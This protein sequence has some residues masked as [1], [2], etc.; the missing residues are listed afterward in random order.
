MAD[1]HLR[2][3]RPYLG[4]STPRPMWLLP[5]ASLIAEAA[6]RIYYRLTVAG[7]QVPGSGPVLLVANHPNSL[8][9]PVL[10][11]AVARRP[12]RY[13]AK[14]PLFTDRM[15]G[16]L[17][18]GSGSIPVY[19]RVDDSQAMSGNVD[20]FRAAH[21]ALAQGAAIGI[22]PEGLSHSEPG[23]ADLKTGAAR[24][25]LGAAADHTSF[26]IVPVG[27]VFRRKHVF[28]SEAFAVIGHPVAWDDLAARSAEDRE[29]VRELTTRI[30]AALRRVTLNLEQWE[31][32]PLVECAEG[33]WTA[34]WGATTDEA[35]RVARLGIT[36]SVL[37]Q[38]RAAPTSRWA[39]AID[40]ITTHCRRLQ[41][42]RLKPGDL[43]RDTRV[44]AGVTW[45]IRRLYLVG[46]PA[47][48]VGVA[49]YTLFWLPYHATDRITRMMK[50]DN[51]RRATYNLLVGIVAYTIWILALGAVVTWRLGLLAGATAVVGVP[52]IGLIGLWTRERWRG[53]WRDARRFFLLRSRGT[54]IATLRRRQTELAEQLREMYGEIAAG[55]SDSSQ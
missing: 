26:P 29:V 50:P 8:L 54:L 6:A 10:V 43:G 13:L 25:A 18:R 30:D 12:V 23:L 27:L 28:R 44:R 35:Q 55:G 2:I 1:S 31:D 15:V 53:A 46:L 16:W 20:T 41:R 48:A 7:A 52:L 9:D 5:A 47:F 37:Q 42:L 3:L 21:T 24:I 11:S 22:F 49:G 51:D 19:R 32:R 39:D 34:Q 36:T 40:G 33:I 14:A 4:D 17:V 45:G 38:L